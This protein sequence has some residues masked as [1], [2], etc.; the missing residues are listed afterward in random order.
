VP[1]LG[2]GFSSIKLYSDNEIAY[3]LLQFC[4]YLFPLTKKS[5][6]SVEWYDMIYVIYLFIYHR[7]TQ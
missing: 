6:E 7:T 2:L 3:L 4:K 5:T 1:I